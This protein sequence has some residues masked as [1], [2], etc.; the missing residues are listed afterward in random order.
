MRAFLSPHD[1]IFFAGTL[2]II[3]AHGPYRS[4]FPRQGRSMESRDLQ[5]WMHIEAMNRGAACTPLQRDKCRCHS[6]L[7]RHECRAPHR[8]FLERAAEPSLP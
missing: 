8:R 1:G 2:K 5:N 6:K 7:K 4:T 3:A